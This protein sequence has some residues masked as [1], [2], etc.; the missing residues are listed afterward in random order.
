MAVIPQEHSC[1][2]G[3]WF[4]VVEGLCSSGSQLFS[5]GIKNKCSE[6]LSSVM[7]GHM[8]CTNMEPF[9]KISGK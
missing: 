9:G 4:H 7:A 1:L 3:G 8:L 6:I 2:L 5:F